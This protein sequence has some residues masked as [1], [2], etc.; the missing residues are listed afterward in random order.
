[1]GRPHRIPPL[2]VADRY[3]TEMQNKS[4]F[5]AKTRSKMKYYYCSHLF[6]SPKRIVCT[7]G[8]PLWSAIAVYQLKIK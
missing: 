2:V 8:A 6:D 3:V 1:M 5:I 7:I 4:S